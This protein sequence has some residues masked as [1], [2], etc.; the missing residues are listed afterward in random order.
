MEAGVALTAMKN[1]IPNLLS[2]LRLGCAPVM[3][4]VAWLAGSRVWFLALLGLMLLTD[5]FD[6]FLAR[7]WN[8]ESDLG[9]RLDSWGDYVGTVATVLGI[10]RLWPDV[11][12]TEWPWFATILA[13]CIGIVAYGLASRGSLLGYHTWLAK[14]LAIVLPPAVFVLLAG[15]AAWPFHAAV[16]LLLLCGIEEMAIAV[17][18]PGYSGH[19]PSFWHAWRNRKKA[20]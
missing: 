2:L 20:G 6:G 3:L 10:W 15:W 13:G 11:I 4:A 7:R 12:R 8:V 18:L 5:A 14:G 17:V 1:R 16:G 19:M 9:R